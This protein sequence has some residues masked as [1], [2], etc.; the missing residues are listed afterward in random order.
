MNDQDTCILIIYQPNYNIV[1]V[2]Y[3]TCTPKT[4][5]H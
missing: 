3:R 1:F 5:C 4:V 2:M